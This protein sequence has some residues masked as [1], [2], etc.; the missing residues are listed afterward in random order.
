VYEAWG[1]DEETHGANRGYG[2]EFQGKAEGAEEGRQ[3]ADVDRSRR[4][5]DALPGQEWRRG[6]EVEEEEE[7]EAQTRDGP[8]GR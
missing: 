3:R 1:G 6:E 2:C 5:G 7:G 8:R 4:A